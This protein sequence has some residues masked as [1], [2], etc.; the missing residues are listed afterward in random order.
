MLTYQFFFVF[1]KQCLVENIQKKFQK[2]FQKKLYSQSSCKWPP[3]M[4]RLGGRLWEVV[5]YGR[6]SLMRAEPILCQ[7]FASLAY[8]KW[9][10]RITPFMWKNNFEK[11]TVLPIEKFSYISYTTYVPVKSKLQHPPSPP[12]I[13]RAFDAFSCPGGREFDHHS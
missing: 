5:A 12:G 7:N 4:L 8:G 13:P 11:N 6:W 3:K 2:K 9:L 10:Q 1:S